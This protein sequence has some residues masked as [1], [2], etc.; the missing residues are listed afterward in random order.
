M[1]VHVDNHCNK[2]QPDALFILNLFRHSTSA[3]FVRIYCP[4]SGGIIVYVQKL[5]CMYYLFRITGSW[6]GEVPS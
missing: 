5:V 3:C 2:N 1:N 6:P 4:S